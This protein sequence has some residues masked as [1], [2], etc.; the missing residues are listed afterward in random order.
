MA[1]FATMFENGGYVGSLSLTH[2]APPQTGDGA[3]A[4]LSTHH[5]GSGNHPA[6]HYDTLRDCPRPSPVV[7]SSCLNEAHP[8]RQRPRE[9]VQAGGLGCV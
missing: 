9:K 1:E 3:S 7:S 8:E 2:E 6:D 4:R 5:G